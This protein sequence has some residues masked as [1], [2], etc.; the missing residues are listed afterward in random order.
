MIHRWLQTLPDELRHAPTSQL[1]VL[2]DEV[3]FNQLQAAPSR[4]LVRSATEFLSELANEYLDDE[5]N[6]AFV[7]LL[8]KEP[9]AIELGLVIVGAQLSRADEIPRIQKFYPA[10]L[11]DRDVLSVVLTTGDRDHPETGLV[12]AILGLREPE[13]AHEILE[14]IKTIEHG[15]TPGTRWPDVHNAQELR[16]AIASLREPWESIAGKML[17]AIRKNNGLLPM[18]LVNALTAPHILPQRQDFVNNINRPRQK[19]SPERLLRSAMAWPLRADRLLEHLELPDGSLRL[20]IAYIE[21][22]WSGLLR[23]VQKCRSNP[24]Y[25]VSNYAEIIQRDI[26]F[27]IAH[28][29]YGGEN[30]AA[31]YTDAPDY[32]QTRKKR[33]SRQRQRCLREGLNTIDSDWVDLLRDIASSYVDGESK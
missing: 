26:A 17:F 2:A 29:T 7:E 5:R 20:H 22:L 23:A 33:L 27:P 3:I 30:I 13:L 10:V 24:S 1:S 9:R 19:L 16:N 11:F 8:V 21:A 4:A 28:G 15:F 25:L 32:D 14:C 12:W 6:T 31:V 18:S